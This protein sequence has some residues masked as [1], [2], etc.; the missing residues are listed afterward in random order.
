M[1]VSMPDFDSVSAEDLNDAKGENLDLSKFSGMVGIGFNIADFRK[2][3][4]PF[5]VLSAY[6]KDPLSR[7]VRFL[8]KDSICTVSMMCVDVFQELVIPT[9]V[10]SS[11]EFDFSVDFKFLKNILQLGGIA[12]FRVSDSGDL[13]VVLSS[14]VVGVDMV[15]VSKFNS[16]DVSDYKLRGTDNINNSLLDLTV[17]T[18]SLFNNYTEKVFMAKG[19]KVYQNTNTVFME[20]TGSTFPDG[21]V[22]RY[23]DLVLIR[24]FVKFN[25]LAPVKFYSSDSRWVLKTDLFTYSFPSVVANF[26]L[27]ILDVCKDSVFIELQ[28][29]FV[30]PILAFIKNICNNGSVL[31]NGATDGVYFRA[32]SF[33]GKNV[34]MKVSEVGIKDEFTFKV[35]SGVLW[36]I[37]SILSYKPVIK[38]GISKSGYMFIDV[39]EGKFIFGR[40]I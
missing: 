8:Y 12:F 14:G 28:S 5:A 9:V 36:K 7:T 35:N 39:D 32:T 31:V 4:S 2:Y 40:Q 33:S 24:A 13:E 16:I 38:V 11:D 34:D 19:S 26:D 3:L 1:E 17:K 18:S 25:T 6:A 22:F 10:N 29:S 27:S 23:M 20:F 30:Q 15:N 37:I 21:F